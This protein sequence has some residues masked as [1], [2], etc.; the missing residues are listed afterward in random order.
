MKLKQ[1]KTWTGILC[2][3]ISIPELNLLFRSQTLSSETSKN[4]ASLAKLSLF[5][6]SLHVAA[7]L[8]FFNVKS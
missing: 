7:P 6:I 1:Q 4:C 3:K 2:Q 8:I 5:F